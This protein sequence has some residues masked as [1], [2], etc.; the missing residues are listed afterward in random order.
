MS[1]LTAI[2][3]PRRRKLLLSRDTEGVHHSPNAL[4]LRVPAHCIASIDALYSNTQSPRNAVP[5]Q[6]LVQQKSAE[7]RANQEA[8]F[9]TEHRLTKEK[10]KAVRF[11]TS[12]TPP[13]L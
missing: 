9:S 1:L 11:G 4:L 6:P 5:T 10:P 7:L 12:R 8:E 3:P 2:S 13:F